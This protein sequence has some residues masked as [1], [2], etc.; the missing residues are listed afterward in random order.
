MFSDTLDGNLTAN[1]ATGDVSV[2]IVKHDNV[3]ITSKQGT[4]QNNSVLE[5]VQILYAT[6]EVSDVMGEIVFTLSE[7]LSVHLTLTAK[8][9]DV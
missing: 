9:M 6:S 2:Y 3:H 5:V 1:L 4:T 7:C 8:Q